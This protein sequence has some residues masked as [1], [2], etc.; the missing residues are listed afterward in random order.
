M[1]LLCRQ[2]WRYVTNMLVVGLCFFLSFRLDGRTQCARQS[3]SNCWAWE[4]QGWGVSHG[5]EGIVQA[6]VL[7]VFTCVHRPQNIFR[8]ESAYKLVHLMFGDFFGSSNAV[9]CQVIRGRVRRLEADLTS[10][11]R[12]AEERGAEMT[13]LQHS[14]DA[15]AALSTERL[16][17]INRLEDDLTIAFKSSSGSIAVGE[18]GS[19]PRATEEGRGTG[20]ERGGE[21]AG[22]EGADALRELLGVAEGGVGVVGGGRG[23]GGGREVDNHGVLEI[24]QVGFA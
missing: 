15:A 1:T 5:R 10:S 9:K 14:L 7:S 19:T 17:T 18:A 23:G 22:S 24:V 11:R 13:R 6:L 2:G 4:Q 16:E 8:R 3:P 12:L 20:F 21:G